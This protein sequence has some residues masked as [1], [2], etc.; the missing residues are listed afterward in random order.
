MSN[1]H[2]IYLLE[3]VRTGLLLGRPLPPL[4]R[5][6]AR[7]IDVTGCKCRGPG[8]S[9]LLLDLVREP[10]VEPRIRK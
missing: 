2:F 1:K 8:S 7:D 10:G 3:P 5:R 4:D 9:C 6:C